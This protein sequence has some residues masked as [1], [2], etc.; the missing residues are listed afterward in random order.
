MTSSPIQ[1]LWNWNTIR[2]RVYLSDIPNFILIK[3]KRAEIQGREIN[4]ELWRKKWVLRHYDLDLWPKITKFN[5]VRA[6]AVSNHLAKT[7]SKSVHLFGWNFVHKKCRTHR[8]TD[9]QTNWSENITPPRFRG[10]IKKAGI[11]LERQN[12]TTAHSS[13]NLLIWVIIFH[14]R[15]SGLSCQI[16][17]H[18]KFSLFEHNLIVQL[19]VEENKLFS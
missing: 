11:K 12:T 6:S 8:H 13:F 7:A 14:L 16:W 5:R 4:R 1:I 9:T 10:G 18:Q 17:S 3:H 2:P 19:W 15:K